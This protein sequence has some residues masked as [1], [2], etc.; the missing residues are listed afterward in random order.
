MNAE[1]AGL[2]EFY[3]L[4]ALRSEWLAIDS[5]CKEIAAKGGVV[6]VSL[7]QNGQSV[8]YSTANLAD[9]MNRKAN[10][11]LAIKIKQGAKPSRGVV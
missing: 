2:I 8:S 7:S 10:L 11:M 6:Q 5:A 3:T 4:E 9:A 1:V